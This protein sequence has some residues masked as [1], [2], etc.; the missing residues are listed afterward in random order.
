MPTYMPK[1]FKHD[2][3][4]RVFGSE[5][6]Y[7]IQRMTDECDL[8][9]Y[10]DEHY[11]READ[12]HGKDIWLSNGSRLYLE[13]GGLVE[14]AT[15][16]VTSARELL[17]HERAGEEI[18]QG[19]TAGMQTDLDVPENSAYKRSG[20]SFARFDHITA[21]H[22][23]NYLTI[24]PAFA[25]MHSRERHESH[26]A[27][28]SYLATRGIWAG[29]GLVADTRFLLTQ[30][31]NSISF[32][33]ESKTLSEGN[34]P[35]Y[36]VQTNSNGLNQ[37]EVRLGDGNMSDWAITNKYA[38]T[39][40]V[41]RLIEHDVFP[42]HLLL[43]PEYA[44]R[45]LYD[46]AR[47]EYIKTDYGYMHPATHQR[48][49]AEACLEFTREFDYIPAEE[50]EAA[51]EV[52][53][54]CRQIEALDHSLEGASTVSDRVDWAA[55][56]TLMAQKLSLLQEKG[57]LLPTNKNHAAVMIDLKWEDIAKDGIARKWYAKYQDPAVTPD[58][59]TLARTLPPPTRAMARTALLQDLR[60]YPDSIT[61]ARVEYDNELISFN[62]PWDPQTQPVL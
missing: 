56:F 26:R 59:I 34:K 58:A 55:K 42:S 28:I 33:G 39:S 31:E 20:Y 40:F 38:L 44:D 62:D 60:E 1:D 11:R 17:A 52:A 29:A 37:L 32:S 48:L 19:I 18:V 47:L 9:P 16:E 3:P 15:P 7:N 5:T 41:L 21:G 30:K 14:Y 54:A 50:I 22:H 4:P 25:G 10:V 6:E 27:L 49:I 35:A 13:V 51:Y 24:I 53:T 43:P 61:W 23:E 57:M 45:A 46:T 2:T 8:R 36:R 12:D